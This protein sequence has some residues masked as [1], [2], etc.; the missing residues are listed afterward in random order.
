M[1]KKLSPRDLQR[2]Q[3]GAV[4]RD[5]EVP[6]LEVRKG[7]RGASWRLKLKGEWIRIGKDLGIEAAREK[8]RQHLGAG[9]GGDLTMKGLMEHWLRTCGRRD[10]KEP[11]RV[12]EK[13]I[14]PW[15][16]EGTLAAGLM[17]R[18]FANW[19]QSLRDEGLSVAAVNRYWGILRA[20]YRTAV[21]DGRLATDE[22]I[23]LVRAG[24]VE[25][26]GDRVYTDDELRTLWNLPGTAGRAM[27][28]VLLTGLR[29]RAAIAM[30]WA[31]V[32]REARLVR[33]PGDVMKMGRP[34]LLPLSEAALEP[35]GDA[36]GDYCFPI[37]ET[38][39]GQ[40]VVRAL[41]TGAQVRTSRRTIAS[42]LEEQGTPREVIET[43]LAHK[44][45]TVAGKNYISAEARLKAHR[46]ALE[47]WQEHLL[48][49]VA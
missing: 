35:L 25:E 8:A 46:E 1:V 9:D 39:I 14:L 40:A 30:Q 29:S 13:R 22:P 7:Q 26:P 48:A 18:D 10:L 3:I 12:W 32:D 20:A 47:A 45:R 42:W 34:F 2:A 6:G 15:F 24:G 27:R 31:W 37:G 33:I 19:T 4:I 49:V 44:P 28:F 38:A 5:G 36:K 41:G 23:R 43:V 21:R 17:R 11:R 16:G